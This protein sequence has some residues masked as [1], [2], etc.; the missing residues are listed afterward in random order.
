M[1]GHIASLIQIICIAAIPLIFA[2]TLHEAAH[3][4]MASKL[5]DQTA[6]IMGR[7]SLNPLR[8]IDP[9]GTVILPLL[10]LSFGGFIFGWAKPVPIAWQHLRH[11]RRDMALVGAAGPAANLLMALFWGIIAKASHLVF[12]SPHTQD[13]LRSTALFI[14]LTSRFG[15]MINCV[16]LVIN[17]I[18]IPP[19]DGSRIVSSILSPQLA[20]KYDRFEAYG[21]WIFLGLLILLYF[22]NSMWIILGPI[23]DLI[24]WIYQLLALPA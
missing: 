10:M 3:G 21:L 19:L 9:F 11:P 13:M 2:I 5:G 14:H 15:I 12:I 22:T 4:W 20:R 7:V 17:L 1:S 23:N 16:L 24:Q 6:R 8:H 18:P